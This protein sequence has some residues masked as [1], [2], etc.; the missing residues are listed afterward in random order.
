MESNIHASVLLNLLNLLQK[1][2]IKCL[3][4]LTF[5]LFSQ[6][7]LIDSIIHK[8]LY[9]T[10]KNPSDKMAHKVESYSMSSG[11]R[12][13]SLNQQ[14]CELEEVSNLVIYNHKN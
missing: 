5:Y 2:M 9:N 12:F 13:F 11:P 10:H 1:K 3:A 14:P 7:C 6:T 4:S 8:L